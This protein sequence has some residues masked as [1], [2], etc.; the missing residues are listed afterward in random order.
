MATQKLLI[1]SQTILTGILIVIIFSVAAFYT[2]M[3]YGS[4]NSL[5]EGKN[6]KEWWL[7]AATR[8]AEK[9]VEDDKQKNI[10]GCIEELK[11]RMATLT[12]N[13][14]NSDGK[15][16]NQTAEQLLEFYNREKQFCLQ[17]Y[18]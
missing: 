9:Y 16:S 13:N 5:Y 1:N 6:A 15:I 17:R 3:K 18:Q 4:K 8:T 12:N 7:E 11:S 2:G 14:A 10:D